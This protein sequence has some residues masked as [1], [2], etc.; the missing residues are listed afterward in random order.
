MNKM[1]VFLPALFLFFGFSSA[2]AQHNYPMLLCPSGDSLRLE[3]AVSEEER[4]LGLM[5]RESLPED[6]GMLFVFEECG[7]HPFWMK[8][9]FFPLDI[10]WMD[11]EGKVL[12]VMDHLPP[13][14][15]DN[16]PEYNPDVNACYV[17]EVNAG[18][19]AEL[20]FT[21]GVTIHMKGVVQH[22]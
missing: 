21:E 14:R 6:M 22:D 7:R 10:I 17:L 3:I 5:F 4:T 12:S 8:N 15:R 2:A 18:K 11:R 9:C 13:C 19:A 16:C 20:G 1:F